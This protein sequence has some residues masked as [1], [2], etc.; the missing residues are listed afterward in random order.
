MTSL[1]A[2]VHPLVDGNS[3]ST[4]VEMSSARINTASGDEEQPYW[5][6]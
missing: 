1:L 2:P 5:E 4:F 3:R 6:L